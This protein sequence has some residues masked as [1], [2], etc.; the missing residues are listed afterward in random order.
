MRKISKLSQLFSALTAAVVLAVMPVHVTVLPAAAATSAKTITITFHANGGAGTMNRVSASQGKDVTLPACTY[1]RKGY[2]FTGWA[3][4][5]N[6]AE[7]EI[8]DQA[9]LQDADSLQLYAIW[10]P[11]MYIIHFNGN[12]A[13]YGAM[14]DIYGIYD[15]QTRL[16]QN[17]FSR[18]R[19]RFAG[20]KAPDGT[21]YAN[22]STVRN[23]DTGNTVSTKVITVSAGK[24]KN[25]RYSFRSTQG[26]CVY[27]E[28]GHQYLVTAAGINDSAYNNGNLSHYETVLTKYDLATG[29]AVARA[30]NLDFDHGNGICY[31]PD[32]GHLYIA[33]GGTCK[34]YPSGVL[35]V[36]QNLKKVKQWDFPL[37]NHVWGIAYADHH[38]YLIGRNDDSRNSFC[39]LNEKMNTLS[40]TPVDEY[41]SQ[42]FSSQGIAAD[43]NFLYAV[44]A[45]F[46]AYEW[47]SKQRINVFDHKGNYIGVWTIDIPYEAEDL[48]I[49]DGYAYI[50]TNEHEQSTL[51]RTKL[52]TVTLTAQ[53]KQ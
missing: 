8:D 44:S 30:R 26:S 38:F 14:D 40:I 4:S 11:Q 15:E 35:E 27:S 50:T 6:A 52:P 47:K 23:L 45:C 48:T 2:V 7:S 13:T 37:L 16:P 17:L 39:V 31:N 41:Y 36:D 33:E 12:N 32:N 19:L 18:N 10:E 53:W 21:I 1:T 25:T 29:K 20:W 5:A 51:Y 43:E 24:P 49:I 9:V 46:S 34:G 28:N 42:H 3:T 22:R